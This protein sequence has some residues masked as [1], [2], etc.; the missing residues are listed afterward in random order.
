MIV[1]FKDID[2][3][4][5]ALQI[6][7]GEKINKLR[8]DKKMSMRELGEKLGIS[9]AHISKLESGINAPSI[10]LLKKLAAFFDI[11]ITYFFISK[12]EEKVFTED[13]KSLLY[14]RDL[15]LESLKKKYTF[16][17]KLEDMEATDEE[18]KTAIE[19]IKTLRRTSMS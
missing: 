8:T 13:E 18:I 11:D 16:I 19:I 15:S 10:E 1:D 2:Q 5:I 6:E 4:L 12:E 17:Q 7:I 9:H 3:K 14:E